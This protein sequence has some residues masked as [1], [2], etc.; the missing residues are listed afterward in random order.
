[1]APEFGKPIHQLP[2]IPALKKHRVHEP[3]DTRFRSAARLLQA[4]WRE[5][6][7]LPIGSCVGEDGKRRKLGSR[8]AEAAGRGGGNFLTPEI[9]HTA[10]RET[11]YGEIGA[12]IDAERLA[13]PPPVNGPSGAPS[14]A[15]RKA[16]GRNRR[17]EGCDERARRLPLPRILEGQLSRPLEC[18]AGP[19]RLGTLFFPR[20]A[21]AAP[22]PIH[23]ATY[24]FSRG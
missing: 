17:L 24:E 1:M 13:E 6:R 10:R 3:L 9:A 4:V 12:L 22:R 19:P 16:H 5:D 21:R 18:S 14:G 23:H 2:L 11:A 20:L 15:S 8:I 7:D